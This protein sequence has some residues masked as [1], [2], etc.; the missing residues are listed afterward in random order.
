MRILDRYLLR[1]ISV[2]FVLGLTLFTLI[3][4]IARILKIIELVVNRG[5][6][7][8]KVLLLFSYI[9]PGFLEITVPMALLLAVLIAL[10]RMASDS[11]ITALRAAG[12]GLARVTRPIL[13]FAAVAFVA[14]LALSL[15]VRPWANALL[16]NGLYEMAKTRATAALRSRVFADDFAGLVLYVD[17]IE[18][19]GNRLNGVL[20]SGNLPHGGNGDTGAPAD[21]QRSTVIAKSGVVISDESAQLV[22]LR[23]FDGSVHTLDSAK[24]GYQ[25][26]DFTTFDI[27]LDIGL[28]LAHAH[29]RPKEPREM[30]LRELR[31]AMVEEQAPGVS[32]AEA[33]E[34]YRR[35]MIPFACLVFAAL[36]VP[37]GVQSS[38]NLRARSLAVSIVVIFVY[39]ALLTCGESLA[40]RG[41]TSPLLGLC[42]PNLVLGA[43]ASLLFLRALEYRPALWHG[44]TSGRN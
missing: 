29:R 2:P 5:V 16:R 6:P 14:N 28:A 39:Y 44:T 18:P 15:H 13:L 35:F 34:Y 32:T 19:P 30:T 42:L 26:T 10:G 25:R 41:Y 31:T 1:E 9:L 24:A 22:M 7:F 38:A 17:R 23:L 27:R 33:I 40:E 4:L 37:L 8:F 20:I 21:S 36:A 12:I 43:I 11:E 3:L